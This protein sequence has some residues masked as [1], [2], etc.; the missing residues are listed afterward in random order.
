MRSARRPREASWP[1]LA[2]PSTTAP[3][4]PRRDATPALAAASPVQLVVEIAPFA[5]FGMDKPHLPR[6]RPVLDIA[7]SLDGRADVFV[8]LQ[9]DQ[10]LQAIAT[11]EPLDEALAMFI[12]S[13][14]RRARKIDVIVVYK[15]DR[16]TRSRLP[17][18]P[19]WSSRSISSKALSFRFGLSISW[20]GK[21]NFV[22]RD[23]RAISAA[24]CG[25]TAG[26]RFADRDTPH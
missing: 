16:L 18:S 24:E 23:W 1:G 21:R 26:I 8:E 19:S 2:R 6:A 15:L 13:P 5:V 12:G 3:K 7:L 11:S 20:S 22:G 25:R 14:L 4:A 10:A 17:T 9:P